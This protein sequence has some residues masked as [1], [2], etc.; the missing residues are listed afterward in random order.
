[1]NKPPFLPV[2]LGLSLVANGALAW[3]VLRRPAAAAGPSSAPT[4]ITTAAAPAKLAPTPGALSAPL[5][6]RLA[7]ARTPDE[8]KGAV[9]E[10][11]AAGLPDSLVRLV[12]QAAV[13]E[14]VMRRRRAIFDYA[15]VPY[16]RDPTPTPE[17]TKAMRA[18]DREVRTLLADLGI[19]PSPLEQA[20][21]QR[22]FA[23]LPEAKAAALEK[24]QQDYNDLRQDL[25]TAQRDRRQ[26]DWMAQEKLLREEQQR[27]IDALLTPAEKL[28]WELRTSGTAAAVRRQVRGVEVTEDEFRALFV[29]QRDYEQVAAPGGRVQGPPSPEQQ[30]RTLAAWDAQQAEMRRVLGDDRYREVAL[31]TAGPGGGRLNEFFALRPEMRADQVTAVLRLAQSMPLE[32][33]RATNVPGLS[34][35][36]R[37][38]RAIAVQERHRADL[39]KVLGAD[40]ARDL[41]ASGALPTL[42]RPAGA[43]AP[44]VRLPGGG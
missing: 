39:T 3:L 42:S 2:L 37:R 18:L 41:L 36:E 24:I 4:G 20:M 40:A 5:A 33:M 13:T 8:L 6:D 44:A 35:D 22:Q 32:L 11:R 23:G 26:E 38:A 14:D 1:M 16:W 21:R 17:Q 28:E 12:V 29:A 31:A 7:A 43:A 25:Y 19:P 30:E 27:D 15:A 9:A 34:A 10:L